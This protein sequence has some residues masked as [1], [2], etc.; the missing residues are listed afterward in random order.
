LSGE[1]VK[2]ES[3]LK[4]A[5]VANVEVVREDMLAATLDIPDYRGNVENNVQTKEA[6][7][8]VQV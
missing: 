3:A 4:S 7:P 1:Q 5:A 8:M 2:N 6:N